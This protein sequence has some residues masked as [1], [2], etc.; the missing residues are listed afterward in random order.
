LEGRGTN[1]SLGTNYVLEEENRV[2]VQTIP[3]LM[4]T[5]GSVIVFISLLGL[6]STLTMN[7]LD[8][9]KEIGML[10]CI[11]ASSA[12]I[13]GVFTTEGVVLAKIGLLFGVP[14]GLALY[15]LLLVMV[16]DVMKLTLL[17][18]FSLAYV[19]IS[20]VITFVGTVVVMLVPVLRA[21]R[22]RPGEALRYE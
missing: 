22:F 4:F 7:I 19:L 5:I 17:W 6:A 2:S 21:V 1:P 11:G 15:W 10:R 18:H 9:M 3:N 20:L 16:R 8:R 13:A 12:A 14:L